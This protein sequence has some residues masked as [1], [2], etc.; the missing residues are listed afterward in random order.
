MNFCNFQKI[1][2]SL[3]IFGFLSLAPQR[4]YSAS[5]LGDSLA[6]IKD[7]S[8]V[9]LI[10]ENSRYVF[11]DQKTYA[12]WYGDDFSKV[13]VISNEEMARY[14]IAGNVTHKYGS[15]IKINTD[16]K[17]YE[18]IDDSGKIQWV[19]TEDIA[20]EKFGINWASQ[21]KDV[22]DE[23]FTNYN[24]IVENQETKNTPPEQTAAQPEKEINFTRITTNS[25]IDKFPAVASTASDYAVAW[26]SSDS[27]R[28]WI[29]A[30]LINGSPLNTTAINL[31][32][33]DTEI[34]LRPKIF[35]DGENYV[36]AWLGKKKGKSQ[37]G[38]YITKIGPDKKAQADIELT[39]A[40]NDTYFDIATNEVAYVLVW[41]QYVSDAKRQYDKEI[42]YQKFNKDGSA[43]KSPKQI[44][45]SNSSVPYPND[46]SGQP[47]LIWNGA[48]FGLFWVDNR[49]NEST[50]GSQINSEIYYTKF[51]SD[52]VK[53]IAETRVTISPT[54]SNAIS[55]VILDPLGYA[56]IHIETSLAGLP[57]GNSDKQ[58]NLLL[59]SD[60][61]ESRIPQLPYGDKNQY[62]IGSSKLI[63]YDNKYYI[64]LDYYSEKKLTKDETEIYLFVF[65]EGTKI[66]QELRLTY[67][68]WQSLSPI[69]VKNNEKLYTLWSDE[70]SC[71]NCYEIW[72]APIQKQ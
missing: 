4:I 11:P 48:K 71:E 58:Y 51:D 44:T 50:Q 43:I 31:G 49:D 3:S 33:E 23:F 7:I 60:R 26:E 35:W 47:R 25:I 52:G 59:L 72:H 5:G 16:P 66:F 15:L 46:Y 65:N 8:S 6:K 68:P 12:S 36:V 40:E 17:V 10:R 55:D 28:S 24:I 38:I 9:Y 64:A 2:L 1:F 67:D 21:V 18:V 19:P 29:S 37:Y 14:P 62:G 20:K 57:E 30:S 45:Y 13:I 42:F 69:L 63:F 56:L 70:R 39:V 61:A 54:L 32:E 34:A 41:E 27:T 53:S 22:P